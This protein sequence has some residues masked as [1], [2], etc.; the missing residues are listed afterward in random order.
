M[1]TVHIHYQFDQFVDEKLIL[2]VVTFTRNQTLFMDVS[3]QFR[4]STSKT[5]VL[6]VD[7]LIFV[8]KISLT[9]LSS[10]EGT[11]KSVFALL[12]YGMSLSVYYQSIVQLR[13]PMIN[14]DGRGFKTGMVY[15]LFF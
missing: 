8:T 6:L 5:E 9:H 15:H 4:F 3:F 14:I 11:I 2:F 1:F 12:I 7:F 13:S 10:Q